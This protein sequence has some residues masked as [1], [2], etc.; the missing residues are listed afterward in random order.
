ML[1]CFGMLAVMLPSCNLFSRVDDPTEETD[2]PE[3]PENPKDT[4]DIDD[5]EKPDT[6]K[7]ST[8]TPVDEEKTIEEIFAEMPAGIYRTTGMSSVESEEILAKTTDGGLF[9]KMNGNPLKNSAHDNDKL[10]GWDGNRLI[11]EFFY[12]SNDNYYF[13]NLREFG[14]TPS[15]YVGYATYESFAWWKA[16]LLEEARAWKTGLWRNVLKKNYE[17]IA[18]AGNFEETYHQIAQMI[19]SGDAPALS[20]QLLNTYAG[21]DV[22]W[23]YVSGKYYPKDMDDKNWVIPFTGSGYME[24]ITIQRVHNWNAPMSHLYWA[25]GGCV[26]DNVS[27]ITVQLSDVSEDEA[28]QYIEQVEASAKYNKTQADG[29]YYDF[30]FHGLTEMEIPE[31][32][33]GI[34]WPEYKCGYESQWPY[35]YNADKKPLLECTFI[36]YLTWLAP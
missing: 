2:D 3:N 12:D 33:N 35:N 23:S 21:Y 5:P 10:F 36:V 4:T 29:W 16:F 11:Y 20:Q 24:K 6:P 17:K 30:Y 1:M 26:I 32:M 25:Y 31:G 22:D 7:D 9:Y 27:Q 18:D 13:Y 15:E 34:M 14:D 28:K 8:T 19:G